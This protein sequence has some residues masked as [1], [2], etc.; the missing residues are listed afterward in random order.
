MKAW[1]NWSGASLAGNLDRP[2]TLGS[3][4][5]VAAAGGVRLHGRTSTTRALRRAHRAAVAAR[6]APGRGSRRP[7]GRG[8]RWAGH[9]KSALLAAWL[10]RR[11]GAGAVVSDPFI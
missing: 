2:W 7:L 9:G 3:L 10:D 1:P 8:D 6:S 4:V 11:G 5:R